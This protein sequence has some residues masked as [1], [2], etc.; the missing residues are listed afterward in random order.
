MINVNLA[1]QIW[2][3]LSSE[4]NVND[5]ITCLKSP[6]FQMVYDE[7]LTQKC[8]ENVNFQFWWNYMEMIFIL[9]DFTRA[10]REGDWEL[11]LDSFRAMFHTFSGTTT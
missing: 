11:Y 3:L 8:Q 6:K 5:L 1:L 9:L 4:Q 2:R 7:F 10:Q